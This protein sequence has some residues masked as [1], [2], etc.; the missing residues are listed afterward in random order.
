MINTTL[1]AGI[2]HGCLLGAA[3][4]VIGCQP[5]D[6]PEPEREAPE[7]TEEIQPMVCEPPDPCIVDITLPDA[8]GERPSAPHEVRVTGGT[9]V[10]FRIDRGPGAANRT[11]LSFEQAAFVDRQDNPIYTLELNPGNNSFTTRPSEANV[12]HPP[13]GCRY[14]V[15]NVGQPGRPSII[16]T[17]HIIIE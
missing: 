6:R 15:I 3:I 7:V 11:V 12:C 10:N 5:D 1:K 17:P 16:S 9:D 14:V 8:A 13:D 4:F 2:I